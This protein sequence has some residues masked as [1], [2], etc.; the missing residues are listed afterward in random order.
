LSSATKPDITLGFL[1]RT[2]IPGIVT[3]CRMTVEGTPWMEEGT[4]VIVNP[5]YKNDDQSACKLPHG[6]PDE[7]QS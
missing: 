2:Q 4:L 1:G 7:F 6:V 3:G 5:F